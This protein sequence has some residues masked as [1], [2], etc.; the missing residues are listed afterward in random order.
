MQNTG[1]LTTWLVNHVFR[2]PIVD[3][4][5]KKD[6][7]SLMEH[8]GLI[9]KFSTS[10]G[11]KYYV[12]AQMRV[13]IGSLRSVVPSS[14][15]PCPLYIDFDTGF[16]PHGVFAQ[17]VCRSISWISGMEIHKNTSKRLQ[18]NREKD[19]IKLSQNGAFF[20]IRRD[21]TAHSLKLVCKKR[22]I[23]IVLK[24]EGEA[25][26]IPDDSSNEM[27][28]QVREFLENTL[29]VLADQFRY[30]HGLQYSLCVACPSCVVEGQE[31]T[32]CGKLGCKQDTCLDLVGVYPGDQMFCTV[33]QEA[34]KVNGIEQWFPKTT[35]EVTR[36]LF[37]F[38]NQRYL[39]A[40]T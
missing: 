30:L 4:V 14:S 39:T 2:P 27:A 1:I 38:H 34:V 24:K 33:T 36:Q 7:L 18:K 8:F 6:I 11:E 35:K 9:A 22:F 37:S 25:Q 40:S 32:K 16:V 31:C 15:D 13:G 12:P 5:V 21:V 26:Q 3:D 20:I 17:I 29:E 19:D 28:T 23:K 10:S